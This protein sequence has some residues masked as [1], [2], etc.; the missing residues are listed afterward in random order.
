MTV[1]HPLRSGKNKAAFA[2]DEAAYLADSS[3][4]TQS[5]DRD[6]SH[7]ESAPSKRGR[8]HQ[9]RATGSTKTRAKRPSEIDTAYPAGAQCLA[10][11]QRHNVQDCYYVNQDKAPEW[12]KP[13]K[14]IYELIEYKRKN[15][16]TFQGLLRGT[17]RTKSQT[18]KIKG[19]SQTPTTQ[20]LDDDQ[21]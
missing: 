6:A 20:E 10:C 9:Q 11:G 12:W 4:A 21:Q 15:D 2:A 7:A 18:P 5:N 14:A 19:K 8:P 1:T 17:S 16:T 3:A 13:N